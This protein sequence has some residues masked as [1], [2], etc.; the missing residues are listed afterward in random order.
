MH[1]LQFISTTTIHLDVHNHHV[2]NGKCWECVHEIRRL[3][4]DEVD[5]MLDVKIFLISLSANK[6][7]LVSNLLY[8]SR[9]GIMELFKGEQLEQI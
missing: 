6:T 5:R 4:V 3:I 2:A 1:R 9:D 7:F 8:D